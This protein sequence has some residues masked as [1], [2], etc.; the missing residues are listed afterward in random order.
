MKIMGILVPSDEKRPMTVVV[1]SGESVFVVPVYF[2]SM[3]FSMIDIIKPDR[4]RVSNY[5]GNEP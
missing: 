1:T 4:I 2:W 5:E 3:I